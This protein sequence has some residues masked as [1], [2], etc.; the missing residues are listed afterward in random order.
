MNG[1]Q[2]GAT[3]VELLVSIVILGVVA[4][5]LGG[6]TWVGLATTAE[7]EVRLVEAGDGR[8]LSDALAADVQNAN[9]IA[10]VDPLCG[11]PG[12]RLALTWTDGSSVR[13]AWV[14][15]STGSTAE[16]VRRHC[17]GT[18]APTEQV[19]ARSLDPGAPLTVTCSSGRVTVV[20]R[21]TTSPPVTVT[22]TSRNGGACP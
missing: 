18:N 10:L 11:G 8:A 1:G 3:L 9:G 6:A 12:T 5:T 4:A 19:V 15:R 22:A 13:A 20:A 21:P 14:V 7:A 17:V 2:E 16:L